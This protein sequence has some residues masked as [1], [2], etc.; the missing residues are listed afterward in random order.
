MSGRTR[1]RALYNSHLRRM[2][3]EKGLEFLDA[4]SPFLGWD[5][6]PDS[7]YLALPGDFHLNQEASEEPLVELIWRHVCA[8][9]VCGLPSQASIPG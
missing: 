2:C 1:L 7:R 3:D 8:E 4:F 9:A 5:G 6:L